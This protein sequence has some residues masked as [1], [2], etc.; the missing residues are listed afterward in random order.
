MSTPELSVNQKLLSSAVDPLLTA[1]EVSEIPKNKEVLIDAAKKLNV[2]ERQALTQKIREQLNRARD[3]LNDTEE[4][5]VESIATAI[6]NLPVNPDN[7]EGAAVSDIFV[8]K[9]ADQQGLGDTIKNFIK[10][11]GFIGTLM[12]AYI[13]F[14]RTWGS[15]FG[16]MD[17]GKVKHIETLHGKYFGGRETAT[18][19][20]QYFKS[21]GY[22]IQ[23]VEGFGDGPAFAELKIQH[24]KLI[25]EKAK[26]M[27][28]SFDN[29]QTPAE[30][31]EVALS[32]AAAAITWES[33]LADKAE[34][35]VIDFPSSKEEPVVTTLTGI[36]RKQRPK[37]APIA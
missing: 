19:Y 36:V 7:P 23:M 37:P 32:A 3:P 29:P 35:Y 14:Q 30:Q 20:N 15:I 5:A 27:D 13:S 31:K 25:R 21:K 28:P 8:E 16:G 18:W 6:E 26:E 33:V 10:S 11:S 17:E 12:S 9:P 4:T 1:Q 2:A 22:A 24:Q 34:K